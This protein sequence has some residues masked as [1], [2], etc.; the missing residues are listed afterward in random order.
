[1]DTTALCA[2]AVL[3]DK[4]RLHDCLRLCGTEIYEELS[5]NV[6]SVLQCRKIHSGSIMAHTLQKLLISE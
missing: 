3:Q 4:G 2:T 6:S 5:K 1:M